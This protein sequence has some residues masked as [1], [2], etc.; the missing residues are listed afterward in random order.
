MFIAIFILAF[1]AGFSTRRG[2]ICLVRASQEIIE[3]KPAKTIIFILEAITISLAITVPSI[4]F[5]PDQINIAQS[6]QFTM[7]LIFGA[8]I[9]G[10]GSALNGGCAIGTLSYLL[11]GNMNF[12]GTFIGMAFGYLIYINTSILSVFSE[13]VPDQNMKHN[14]IYLVTILIVSWGFTAWRVKQFLKPSGEKVSK[15]FKY[16]LTSS[17]ARDFIAIFILG[18]TCGILFL[19]LGHSWNHIRW[20]FSTGEILSGRNMVDEQFQSIT[21]TTISFILGI[22]AATLLSKSFK[23]S[24]FK[25]FKFLKKIAGGVFIAIGVIFIP[26]GNDTLILYDVPGLSFHAPIALIVIMMSIVAS[27]LLTKIK[28]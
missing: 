15:S 28:F 18:I 16:F 20:L 14:I 25:L 26:G 8:L 21:V 3:K 19:M 17:V 2:T 24:S 9:Y 23:L 5:F 6:Y 10:F 7:S 12:L 4:I 22:L 27:L 1:L 13:P 11:N